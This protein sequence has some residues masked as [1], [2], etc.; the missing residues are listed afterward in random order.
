MCIL[1]LNTT[2]L[3]QIVYDYFGVFFSLKIN[4]GNKYVISS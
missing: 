3:I 4:S 1:E 2:K